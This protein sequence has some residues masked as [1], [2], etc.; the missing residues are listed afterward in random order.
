MSIHTDEKYVMLLSPLLE[1]FS[2][3]D[4]RLWNFR[5]PFCGDSHKNK[6][7][8]RGY[9]YQRGDNLMFYC[10]NCPESGPLR[11]LLYHVNSALAREYTTETYLE[12]KELSS[13]QFKPKSLPSGRL[14]IP[15]NDTEIPN[16]TRIS[17]LPADHVSTRYL[18]KRKIPV[19]FFSELFFSENYATTIQSL[20]GPKKKIEMISE[21]RIVIPLRNEKNILIGLTGRAIENSKL[22]YITIKVLKNE[23]KIFGLNRVNKSEPIYVVEGPFDSMFLPNSIATLDANLTKVNELDINPILIFDNEPRNK[24][25]LKHMEKALSMGMKI[26]VWPKEVSGIKDINNMILSG[27]TPE[28][29]KTLIDNNTHSGIRAKLEMNRWIKQW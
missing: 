4:V 27:Y 21:K 6:H 7:K 12:K 26:C 8:A 1:K 23:P 15:T 5:C 13:L 24:I 16:A 25:L 14:L 18:L 10:H 28:Q 29:L 3:K 19:K 2:K 22:R 11:K 20:I 9:I 17:D